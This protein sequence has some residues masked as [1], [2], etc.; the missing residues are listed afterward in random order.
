MNNITN[1]SAEQ[2][3]AI[4]LD[5]AEHELT[6]HIV[7]HKLALKEK[8]TE[9]RDILEKLS[10]EEKKHYE[11]W[12]SLVNDEKEIKPVGFTV[13]GIPMLR[14][15]L[16]ITFTIKLL[17][18]HENDAVDKYENRT[19]PIIPESH[20]ERFVQVIEDEKSHERL[21]ISQIQEKRIEYISFIALGLADAI[22]EITGV[23][24]GF[25]G[26]TGTP[27]IAGVSGI[28]VGFAASISMGS[29]AYI[30][31]KQDAQKN[32]VTS[33]ITTG[34]SY[35]GSVVVLALPYFFIKTMYPAFIVSTICGILLLAAF[36][37]YGAIVFDRK[38]WRELGESVFLML[39]TAVATFILGK[40]VGKV[41]HIKTSSF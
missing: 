37:F 22:V 24:A 31:A 19:E 7:Y 35:L 10:Q 18:L 2:R 32:P 1:L 40:V 13:W 33:A 9:N 41:F 8:K 25:L 30:Q 20:K 38:F 15:T 6:E 26:V 11:F 29:A 34:L 5:Y 12:K 3:K 23:H 28:I 27:L 16:G 39:A 36:T 17:E 4:Y 14:A 21:L